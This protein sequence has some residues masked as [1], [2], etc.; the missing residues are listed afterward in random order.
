MKNIN[1]ELNY[2][3]Y[4]LSYQKGRLIS[5]QVTTPPTTTQYTV[6]NTQNTQDNTNT[7]YMCSTNDANLIDTIDNEVKTVGNVQ[8]LVD[9]VTNLTSVPAG[10][11]QE[12]D[13]KTQIQTLINEIQKLPTTS[14]ENLTIDNLRALIPIFLKLKKPAAN[15]TPTETQTNKTEISENP[16]DPDDPYQMSTLERSFP[17]LYPYLQKIKPWMWITMAAYFLCIILRCLIYKLQASIG[18]KCALKWKKSFIAA[19]T[20]IFLLDFKNLKNR[21]NNKMYGCNWILGKKGL[22]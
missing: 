21:K 5:E 9:E 19:L 3:R 16:D 8:G 2:M 20:Q 1:E 22:K 4:L 17:E 10:S 15:Q 18:F 13:Y 12:G 14:L 6:T 7:Q 11:D